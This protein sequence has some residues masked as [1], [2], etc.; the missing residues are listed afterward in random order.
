MYGY[1]PF[2]LK[3]IIQESKIKLNLNEYGTYWILFNLD[4]YF[5]EKYII[6]ENSIMRS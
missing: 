3:A 5:F 4:K 1:L 2:S 6:T